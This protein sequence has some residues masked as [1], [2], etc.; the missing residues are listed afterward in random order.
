MTAMAIVP[1]ASAA[2]TI[3][4]GETQYSK[5][6]L[7]KDGAVDQKDV[8][9][10]VAAYGKT[11][12]PG[13]IPA[14]INKDGK[15]NAI[16]ASGLVNH[17]GEVH[18]PSLNVAS[19]V[20]MASAGDTVYVLI[21]TYKENVV[22]DK[23]ITLQGENNAKTILDGTGHTFVVKVLGKGVTITGF[24]IKNGQSG[25]WADTKLNSYT[26]NKFINNKKDITEPTTPQGSL[27]NK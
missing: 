7:N 10:F 23:A 16:D 9:V 12:A 20:K 25:I 26:G 22:V 11:G 1:M 3:Y 15:V 13:W 21:G 24:T 6:D 17:Y 19:A 4:V 5:Y 27:V 14:D 8:D 2:R 18:M